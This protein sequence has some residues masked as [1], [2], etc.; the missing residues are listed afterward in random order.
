ML[1]SAS[2]REMTSEG[3]AQRVLVS[4]DVTGDGFSTDKSNEDVE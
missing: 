2:C 3:I 4:D 1:V